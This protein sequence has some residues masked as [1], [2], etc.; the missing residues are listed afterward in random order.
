MDAGGPS[1]RDIEYSVEEALGQF[2]RSKSTASART[3]PLTQEYEASR[4]RAL[5]GDEV[6]SLFRDAVSEP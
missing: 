2:L 1:Q 4:T 5:S 6:A 3:D